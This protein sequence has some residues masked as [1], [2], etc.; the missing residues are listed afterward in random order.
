MKKLTR[1]SLDEMAMN[2]SEISKDEQ[3]LFVGGTRVVINVNR[4]GYGTSST[5][6]SFLATAYDDDGNYISSMSG[7]FLEPG[8]DYDQSTIA[9]SDT[10]IS[11][12]SY[13]VEHGSYHHDP[14]YYEV[15]GVEGRSGIF[16][17][18]GNSGEDTT[19]CFLPGT[20]STYDSETDNY[21]VSD[22]NS[23]RKELTD[24]LDKY[25]SGGIEMNI[26]PNF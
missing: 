12:G 20:S 10:A 16:I 11:G 26:Y 19:G 7:M 24:F 18:N 17:H 15:T 22:S 1:K 5:L 25:G 4:T 2:M 21:S 3:Q 8:T 13:N 9:G 23:K 14:S 6:S